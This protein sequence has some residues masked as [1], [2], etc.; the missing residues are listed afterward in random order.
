MADYNENF[1]QALK[2]D[3]SCSKFGTV[4]MN[5][6][7]HKFADHE[8]H[9]LTQVCKK[10]GITTLWRTEDDGSWTANFI[11]EEHASRQTRS[12]ALRLHKS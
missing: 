5:Y 9:Q 10:E 7:N 3:L 6:G 4:E 11:K 8:Q 12:C 2:E 1:L